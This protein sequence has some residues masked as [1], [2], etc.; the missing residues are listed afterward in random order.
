MPSTAL[1]HTSGQRCG[2]ILHLQHSESPQKLFKF[3]E[4]SRLDTIS[5]FE[6]VSAAEMMFM[7]S[8][9]DKT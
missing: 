6:L 2:I 3:S 5:L 1:K 4:T 8:C 9:S 7:L